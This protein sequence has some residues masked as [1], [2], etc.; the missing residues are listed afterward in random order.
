MGTFLKTRK[1]KLVFVQITSPEYKMSMFKKLNKIEHINLTLFTG[2]TGTHT[3][4][5]IIKKKCNLDIVSLNNLV[6][7]FLGITILWQN[8]V[9]RL[10]VRKYDVVILPDGL[11]YLSNYLILLKCKL[12][13]T[14]VGLYTHGYNHQI[15]D[16]FKFKI[17]EWLRS[18]IHRFYDALIVY[19]ND[20]A[21]YLQKRGINQKKIFVAKNTLDVEQIIKESDSMSE[22]A[23]LEKKKAS[24][25]NPKDIIICFLGRIV[26]IKRP[27][28]LL[29][30]IYRLRKTGINASAL[31][32]GSGSSISVLE[33]MLGSKYNSVYNYVKFTGYVNS[34]EATKYIKLSDIVAIPGMT[35]LAIVHAFAVGKPF[36]TVDNQ[37]HSP[38]ITYL[39][40]GNN[41]LLTDDNF[42]SFYTSLKSLIENKSEMM[43]LGKNARNYSI[44][45]LTIDQ[46]IKGFLSFVNY[47]KGL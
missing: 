29:K 28:W 1:V 34:S 16:P 30:S 2:Y 10:N 35:G 19:T 8:L 18:I 44:E 47:V 42:N 45:N 5:P 7:R 25:F 33:N 38:E 27:E 41:G 20:G 46:Q 22:S 32:V 36:I 4:P 40:P 13:H 11:F 12:N 14:S 15:L 17:A 6:C 23:I 3:S 26:P 31:Y 43:R 21:E 24:W 37:T 9:N 39:Q